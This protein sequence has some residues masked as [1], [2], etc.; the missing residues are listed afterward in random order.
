MIRNASFRTY[1]FPFKQHGWSTIIFKFLFPIRSLRNWAWNYFLSLVFSANF[2]LLG[3][4]LSMLVVLY[5]VVLHLVV[6][7]PITCW[8]MDFSSVVNMNL[9]K[10][11]KSTKSH[12]RVLYRALFHW[13][14]CI[15]KKLLE[16]NFCYYCCC[17]VLLL[18]SRLVMAFEYCLLAF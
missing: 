9:R 15:K 1:H 2:F 10:T 7:I 18:P 17:W 3:S 14:F 11:F 13:V 16:R 4:H 5:I 8:S 12:A 6:F